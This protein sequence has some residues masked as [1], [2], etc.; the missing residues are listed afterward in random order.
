M[1]YVCLRVAKNISK[2]GL[3]QRFKA[4]DWVEVGNQTADLWIKANEAYSTD[5]MVSELPF[6]SAG[7]VIRDSQ[8][9]QHAQI[10]KVVQAL[11]LD[12]HISGQWDV[13]RYAETCIW[14]PGTKLRPDLIAQGFALLDKWHIVVPMCPDGVLA[15]NT[16]PEAEREKTAALLGD[17]RV[18]LRDTRMIFVRRCEVT[19]ALWADLHKELAEGADERH[20]FL[21]ALWTHI[22]K[23]CD[24]PPTWV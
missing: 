23:V 9:L 8:A 16:G 1:K 14:T 10:S 7:L 24:V 6:Q 15:S 22:P 11:S 19:R 12:A 5:E 17:G 3:I 13:L 21:R 4:G 2:N 20:A 18:P